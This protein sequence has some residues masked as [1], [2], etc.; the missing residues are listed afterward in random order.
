[1]SEHET[2]P[3]PED[4][5]PRSHAMCW[6]G[7]EYEHQCQRPSG[8]RCINCGEPAGTLWGPIWCPPCDV[9]RLDSVSAS[10]EALFTG[11]DRG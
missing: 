1:M 10:L 7:S 6:T 3:F 4:V 8:R 5:T 11:G 2:Q 9:I